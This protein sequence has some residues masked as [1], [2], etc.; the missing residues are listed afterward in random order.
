MEI[1]LKIELTGLE[2]L[3]KVLENLNIC[4]NVEA[5]Q[6]TP[7]QS[8]QPV[9]QTPVQPVQ[10]AQTTPA[11]TVTFEELQA[12]CIELI[13]AGKRDE[14]LAALKELG[15]VS[16]T[17]IPENELGKAMEKIKTIK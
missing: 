8:T 6:Q 15:Y 9:Q 11:Q 7:V 16:I 10:P 1:K 3:V 13:Q 12:R 17:D 2:P 5:A 14:T 4:R